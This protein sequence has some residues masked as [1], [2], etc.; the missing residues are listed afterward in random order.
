MKNIHKKNFASD[1]Y[2]GM[3]PDILQAI[4]S[5]NEHAQKAYGDD[6]YTAA[7]V[8]LFK[9]QFGSD[10]DVYFVV[11]GTAANIL[12]LSAVLKPYQ[13]VLCSQVAHINVDECGAFEKY[14]GSKLLTITTTDGKI[15][16]DDIKTKLFDC[17]NQHRVQPKIVSISQSTELG[18]LYSQEEIKNITEFAHAHNMLV[19]MDGARLS[20]A[21]AS[22]NLSLSALTRDVGID[23]VSFGGTKDGMMFGEAVIFFDKKLSEDF[24]YIRKQGMQLISKMRFIAAQFI[25]LLSNDLWRRNAHHAN[26][27]A[28]LL[29]AEIKKNS[30]IVISRPVQSNAVFAYVDARL[31]VALQEKYYFYVWDEATHEVRWMT[32]FNTTE[33]DVFDFVADIK[34]NTQSLY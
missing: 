18:T 17:G 6:D 34:Q 13:A 31:I 15:T 7:A 24:K 27:M 8:E 29:H 28:Q 4:A 30:E 33:Q 5:V 32:S 23:I 16:V 3:H 20:N 19:H 9:Q 14:T 10:I 21:A 26:A 1:N 2:A 22:L 11:N 12:G 25:A